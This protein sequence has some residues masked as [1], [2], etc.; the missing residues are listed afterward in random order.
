MIDEAAIN[1][2]SLIDRGRAGEV[3]PSRVLDEI[4]KRCRTAT[5]RVYHAE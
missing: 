5:A 3:A 2:I 4:V 1:A